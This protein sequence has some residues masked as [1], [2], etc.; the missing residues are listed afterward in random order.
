MKRR[1]GSR[2]ASRGLAKVESDDG[3]TLVAFAAKAGSTAADDNG[4]SS[5]FGNHSPYTAA[6]LAHLTTPGLD[7]RFALGK[8]H[9]DVVAQTRQAGQVQTPWV[10]GALGGDVL[11]LVPG[12][13][14]PKADAA[15]AATTAPVNLPPSAD[16]PTAGGQT[17]AEILAQAQEAARLANEAL[18]AMQ[19][20]SSRIPPSAP[21]KEVASLP[22]AG[23][24]MP[25]DTPQ[26]PRNRSTGRNYHYV[27]HLD[28][29]GDNFLAL[30]VAPDVKS[31][32]IMKMGPNTLLDVVGR[33]GPWLQVVLT[34]GQSGWA[35][36]KY[37]EC[38]RPATDQ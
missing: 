14:P 27:T 5:P 26:P 11:A 34:T 37:V 35:Y 24:D 21:P 3:A 2:G 20:G 36:G 13:Q 19:Q 28:P 15:S 7:L 22:E 30:K 10:Y 9:D 1:N 18:K 6:L 38:C 23:T 16:G 4:G 33:R 12:T 17:P 32:R 25:E 31:T 8:V 29:N